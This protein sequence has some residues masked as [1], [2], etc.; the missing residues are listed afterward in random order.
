MTSN[1][2]RSKHAEARLWIA[3][4][5]AAGVTGLEFSGGLVSRSLALVSD[6]GHIFT[7]VLS[8]GIS[9]LTLRLARKPHSATRTFGYHRAEIF[10]ALLNG[11]TLIAIALFIIYQSY[12]RFLHPVQV[13]GNLVMIIASVGLVSNLGLARLLARSRQTSL[14]VRGIFLHTIGD[15]LSSVAVILSAL[16]ILLTGYLLA[17]PI[18]AVVIGLLIMRSAYSL[19]RESL[20][21]LLEAT[22]K[23][24]KLADVSQAILSVEG[25][26]GVHDLH[27]WTITSGLY[28][29]SGHITLST[30]TVKEANMIREKAA[31]KLAESFGIEHVT[32]QVET[33]SLE[34]IQRNEEPG[35]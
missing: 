14:N 27:V 3:L 21:I 26:K 29:L 11:S 10:A 6:A 32:L 31:R 19:V 7:D 23:H 22:P 15:I 35:I 12:R 30:N 34:T 33:E 24:L 1:A 20:D 2:A 4:A 5:V 18:I 25:V 16:V 17:D 28:A 9:I 8:I 13:E